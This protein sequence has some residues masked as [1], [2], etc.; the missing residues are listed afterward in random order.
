MTE[1]SIRDKS[2]KL[3]YQCLQGIQRA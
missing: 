2:D 1:V 3:K